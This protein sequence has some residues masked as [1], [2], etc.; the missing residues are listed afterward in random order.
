[1]L[2]EIGGDCTPSRLA[3]RWIAPALPSFFALYPQ[4]TL[5][6]GGSDRIVDLVREGVD[7]AVRVGEL[8]SSS[9]VARPLGSLRMINCASPAYRAKM[10]TPLSPADLPQHQAV[11]YAAG[12]GPVAPWLWQDQG[13]LRTYV[14]QAQVVTHNVETY[15][16]CA[17]AGLGL[18]QVPAFDVQDK[19]DAATLVP[20]LQAWPAPSM[21]MH[22]MYAHKRQLSRR[23]QA[24]SQ[25]LVQTLEPVLTDSTPR[26]EPA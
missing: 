7:C 14:M 18:I 10:G 4:M 24:F 1:M 21:P 12:G 8:A 16:A 22:L 25:W 5:E 23:L 3:R 19:L 11:N 2:R 20:V 26:R 6:L 13:E 15:I 9:L 17:L